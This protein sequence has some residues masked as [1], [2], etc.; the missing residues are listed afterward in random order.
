MVVGFNCAN[1]MQTGWEGRE[2]HGR[3][4]SG[5]MTTTVIS[6][7]NVDIIIK[8]AFV[9]MKGCVVE[10]VVELDTAL[11]DEVVNSRRGMRIIMKRNNRFIE[12]VQVNMLILGE[13]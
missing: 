6:D 9:V 5:I 13:I 2:G 11:G 7:I 8:R 10:V 4:R 1:E 3:K 12:K